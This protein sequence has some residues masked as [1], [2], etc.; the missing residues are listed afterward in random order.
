M[1]KPDT[2]AVARIALEFMKDEIKADLKAGIVITDS[3]KEST[4]AL[5]EGAYDA[6]DD[7]DAFVDMMREGIEEDLETSKDLH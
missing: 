7:I 6:L 3:A 2:L 5:L 4:K 1:L